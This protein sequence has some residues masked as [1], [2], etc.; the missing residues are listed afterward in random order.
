[1]PLSISVRTAKPLDTKADVLVI[2]VW[3]APSSSRAKDGAA[4]K[5]AKGKQ[6][7]AKEGAGATPL[8]ATLAHIGATM[9]IPGES[10]PAASTILAYVAS[11]IRFWQGPLQRPRW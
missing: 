4:K 6:P 5:A 7:K 10:M 3:S 8:D 9:G 1:M 2:G 11:S